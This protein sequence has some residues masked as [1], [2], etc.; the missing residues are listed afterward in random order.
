[1]LDQTEEDCLHSNQALVAAP[2]YGADFKAGGL[3]SYVTFDDNVRLNDTGGT[4]TGG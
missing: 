2:V 1:M 3:F 4:L